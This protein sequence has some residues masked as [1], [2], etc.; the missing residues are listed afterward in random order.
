[1]NSLGVIAIDNVAFNEE[2]CPGKKWWTFGPSGFLNRINAACSAATD[3]LEGKR[4]L[5]VR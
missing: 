5:Y 3:G 4:R 1:M 2:N